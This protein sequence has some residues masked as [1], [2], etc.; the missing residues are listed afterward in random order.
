MG[1]RQIVAYGPWLPAEVLQALDD[2]R[3]MF[4]CGA[5]ISMSSE[6]WGL[7][8][9][10]ELTRLAY[11]RCNQPMVGSQPTD[12]AAHDAVCREQYD[13]ALE[14]LET[15]EGYR[16]QMRRV[17]AEILTS[18]KGL[19]EPT[20][21]PERLP[22]HRALLDLAEL[23]SAD[24]KQK[25]YRL[26]TTNFDNRFE[27]AGLDL[28]LNE[29]G[30]RLRPP[31]HEGPSPL[32]HLHGGVDVHDL[33]HRDLV[34]TTRDFGNAYLRHGW[35]ARFVVE[36]FREFTVLF[37]GYSLSD[38]VM[39]YLMDVFAT[40]S[41]ERRQ[42]RSAFALVSYDSGKPGDR[43]QQAKLWEAKRVTPV[44]YNGDQDPDRRHGLLDDTLVAWAAERRL[45][46][47]GRLKVA[48]DATTAEFRPGTDDSD[49]LNSLASVVWALDTA[50]GEIARRYA[51]HEPSPHISWFGAIVERLERRSVDSGQGPDSR[52]GTIAKPSNLPSNS[53]A[54]ALAHW[55]CKHLTSKALT[56]WVSTSSKPLFPEFGDA[57]EQK[58]SLR[59]SSIGE[60]IER[61][62]RLALLAGQRPNNIEH[63][64][65]R[66]SARSGAER[67]AA[68]L[69]ELK[70]RLLGPMPSDR[71]WF[72]S[73]LS[74]KDVDPNTA[75]AVA[76]L[77]RFDI[78]HAGDYAFHARNL[79]KTVV[80]T[81]SAPPV[82]LL[83]A[84]DA[85]T[86]VLVEWVELAALAEKSLGRGLSTR[87]R[88]H[89][90][91][92]ADADRHDRDLDVLIDLTIASFSGLAESRPEEAGAVASRWQLLG[93]RVGHTIFTR[94]WL[95]AAADFGLL[96]AAKALDF[97]VERPE[98]LWCAEYEREALRFLRLRA[99]HAGHR[100][101]AR[102]SAALMRRL[103]AAALPDHIRGR[104][105]RQH[106]MDQRS[107]R[108]WKASL[109][110]VALKGRAACL[111][112]ARA[113]K[114]GELGVDED[115]YEVDR[116]I[117][118]DEMAK[119]FPEPEPRPLI[120]KPATDIVAAIMHCADGW[121]RAHL[122]EGVAAN[123]PSR[124]AE[125][126]QA[127]RVAGLTEPPPYS[128]VFWGLLFLADRKADTAQLLGPIA[129]VLAADSAL[130]ALCLDG[131]A[132]WLKRIWAA[133]APEAPYAHDFW[134]FWD[135]L[136]A[137]ER[138]FVVPEQDDERPY[139]T[140]LN[141]AG[142]SLADVLIEN[143]GQL[144]GPAGRGL[145][146]LHRARFDRLA[147]DPGEIGIVGRVMVVMRLR[148]LY[149]VDPGWTERNLLPRFGWN[150][151]DQ[152]ETI[153]LWRTFAFRPLLG[154]TLLTKLACSFLESLRRRNE[155]GQQAFHSLCR[156]L[157]EIIV[158]TPSMF[159]RDQTVS[160]IHIVGPEGCA[161]V[162]EAFQHKLRA[163]GDSAANLW[164][165]RIGPWLERYWPA[166]QELRS[167]RLA[168]EAIEVTFLTREAFPQ[169]VALIQDKFLIE[170][171]DDNQL[172]V[173]SLHHKSN[174]QYYA[175]LARHT[176][177]VGRLLTKA[178]SKK[179]IDFGR[180]DMR[181]IIERLKQLY[182]G[183]IPEGWQ[184]LYNR[185]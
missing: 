16:G 148:W 141:A 9:F 67:S 166:N 116:P 161:S 74:E 126:L 71:G 132:A 60:P 14:I 6:P 131:A 128:G 169:A 123:E 120:G 73:L 115:V 163:V 21:R 149:A 162:L 121:D 42:F 125:I 182:P 53:V 100:P 47:A 108:L 18:M 66:R 94:L 177:E 139:D 159:D 65:R 49:P 143:E 15:H 31:S 70:P 184:S 80:Q 111:A 118:R 112:A 25:G 135:L 153:R 36:M 4:F 84:A 3:L 180:S 122:A 20:S 146:E 24:G 22:R 86:S 109:G 127:M 1:G 51:E 33:E 87:A 85:L 44:L 167:G 164:R 156:L 176:V 150:W 2:G 130:A 8:G 10:G 170:D 5:G 64:W 13:K 178:L 145:S 165:E 19:E 129:E 57:V 39:R 77:G 110:G 93:N 107:L 82:E 185:Y 102:L 183:Q 152:D 34:L 157:G 151:S 96:D 72:N 144:G 88:S 81:G 46:L 95:W 38:P 106:I 52:P 27:L 158:E 79:H 48:T 147:A 124:A 137:V 28:V 40:E 75:D 92:Q 7:P 90:V 174:D 37:I 23:R 62:W 117:S 30:P 97:I 103:P 154:P 140:A 160:T 181:Q 58:L 56:E 175:Y 61:F 50:E 171:V 69:A 78:V 104:D 55:A 179:P 54:R 99:G 91:R 155:L 133:S 138:D 83:D 142:G 12:I 98:I 63:M 26:V 119:H 68:I 168:R 76:D 35:A 172:W 45:G 105:L 114:W 134:R 89:L 113:K 101:Q 136:A 17:V 32:V 11:E 59:D 173:F 43:E 41:G 29:D